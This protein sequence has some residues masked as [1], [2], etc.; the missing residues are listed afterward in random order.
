MRKRI[1][2]LVLALAMLFSLP[3]G[4]AQED[5][6][7]V[8]DPGHGGIDSGTKFE[9]DGAEV[10]ESTLNLA[11][12]MACRDY[13]EAH[14]EN[15]RV[16]LTRETDKKVSLE[17]RITFADL[18]NADYM[19]SIHLNSDKGTARGALAL[20]PR[21]RYR[22][23]QAK[24][25]TKTALAILEEMEALGLKNL[26]TT[27]LLSSSR[28]PDGT[29]EDSLAIIRGCVYENIPGIIMEHAFLDNEQDY[30]EFLSTP[31]KL[32][33]L[34]KA[35][36]LGLA[37]TLDLVERE[38]PLEP[39]PELPEE[40]QEP[41]FP[42]RDVTEGAWYYESVH[43]VWAQGLMQGI[44]DREFGPSR[45]AN[46][47]MVVTLLHRLANPGIAYTASSF[48]DVKVGEWYH[49]AVE[50]ALENGITTGVS[51]T[52]FAPG[53]NVIREQFVTFLHRYA[54]SP[55]PDAL[56]E[57]FTDWDQVS[58]YA[59][60]PLAWAV[61]EGLLTGYDDGSVKPLRELNRAELA[62][63]MERFH[64]WLLENEDKLPL[65]WTLSP[66][67][68][69]LHPGESFE[70]TLRS[71][72]GTLAQPQWHSGDEAVATVDGSTV[73]AQGEGTTAIRCTWEG[74]EF[75]CL[76][77][78]TEKVVT[79]RISHTDVTIKPGESFNLRL[80]SSEGETAAVE[81]QASKSG[82]VTISG[83]KITGK[84]KG[85]VTVSCE[86]AGETWKCIVRVKGS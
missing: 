53:R 20:V 56:P 22:P 58:G 37:K 76:V 65:R 49:G 57:E 83:N 69:E 7:I 29:Y 1:V 26:G 35:D 9:Y 54:G 10:W 59:Q 74:E 70:L 39:G 18:K 40:P 38:T 32:A 80:R 81:W 51:D 8:L 5:V 71:Q 27:Y 6:V 21:G 52:Q 75:E 72:F 42:F 3:V 31:E 66:E 25:S 68:A 13:L 11:I 85:T 34:G 43:Y 84:A 79:W 55:E 28:Y 17:E 67:T 60:K 15:V 73:T 46:R 41:V 77:T 44:S 82:I 61:E 36:A 4:A 30:R 62:V 45:K 14:Y 78:V 12:A 16:Y 47:A 48:A 50:W 24:A 23:E 86:F 19:L 64:L 63:L 33:A 2:A